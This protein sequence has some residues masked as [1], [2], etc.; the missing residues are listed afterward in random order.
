MYFTNNY[1]C[2]VIGSEIVG[3]EGSDDHGEGSGDL[4]DEVPEGKSHT[5]TYTHPF[6]IT[7]I[8]ITLGSKA[9]DDGMQIKSSGDL[10]ESAED[11]D[12]VGE[13]V[14]HLGGSGDFETLGGKLQIIISCNF[15]YIMS[16]T[17]TNHIF[18]HTHTHTS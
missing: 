16:C 9:T 4:G 5:H 12:P 8:S 7:Y 2:Y 10:E 11:N 17:F 1:Y 14:E 18:V 13:D 15:V 3:G 6:V